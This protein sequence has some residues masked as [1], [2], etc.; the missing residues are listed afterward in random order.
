MTRIEEKRAPSD[1]GVELRT[2][3]K[4]SAY[5]RRRLWSSFRESSTLKA[6]AS[7]ATIVSVFVGIAALWFQI[8][9]PDRTDV[10]DRRRSTT[11]ETSGSPVELTSGALGAGICLDG[12]LGAVDCSARHQY[13]VVGPGGDACTPDAV[14]THLGGEVTLDVVILEARSVEAA[15]DQVCVAA[16]NNRE[17]VSPLHEALRQAGSAQWR[18]CLDTRL[19]PRDVPCNEDHTAEYVGAGASSQETTDCV[20]TVEQYMGVTLSRVNDRLKVDTVRL[21]LDGQA[22]QRCLISVLGSA[23][24]TDSVRSIEARALPL[25]QP[26]S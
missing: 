6:F 15:G 8:T 22:S 7:V 2:I 17:L 14:V 19:S 11:S 16:V 20:P 9:D 23:V 26:G 10:E 24:L 3:A 25:K 13:E 1:K 5:K 18:R 12:A 4:S 21:D